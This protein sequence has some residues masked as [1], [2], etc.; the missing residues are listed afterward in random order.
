[1]LRLLRRLLT[2]VNARLSGYQ[3]F[4]PRT[5]G[6]WRFLEKSI[7]VG[8]G[9]VFDVGANRGEWAMQALAFHPRARLH[10]FEPGGTAFGE[11]TSALGDRAQVHKAAVSSEPGTVV[12]HATEDSEQSSLFSRRQFGEA[13]KSETVEAVTI[14]QICE[15]EGIEEIALLKIDTEGNELAVLKGA[16]GTLPRIKTIQ[17]EYGGTAVDARIYLRDFFDLLSD[18][19]DLYRLW[20]FG[21]IHE[22]NWHEMLELAAYQNWVC[23]QRQ[24]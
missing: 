4:D 9:I 7:D 12:L 15:R 16:V 5:N 1:M 17:F 13:T 22:P 10:C 14:D 3:S 11:L 2:K 24:G 18:H 23:I 20:R 21:I 8:D 6:E 19:F